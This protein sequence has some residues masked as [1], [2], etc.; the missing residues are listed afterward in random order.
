MNKVKSQILHKKFTVNP[1]V[2]QKAFLLNLIVKKNED[3]K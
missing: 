2:K 3:K 1:V